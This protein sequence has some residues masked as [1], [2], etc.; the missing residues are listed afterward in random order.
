[1]ILTRA[2]DH[3]FASIPLGVVRVCCDDPPESLHVAR[4]SRAALAVMSCLKPD[5]KICRWLALTSTSI[6]VWAKRAGE[7]IGGGQASPTSDSPGCCS[8]RTT[9]RWGLS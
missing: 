7:A 8:T 2:T 6:G 1:V 3:D 4:A 9:A 5:Q